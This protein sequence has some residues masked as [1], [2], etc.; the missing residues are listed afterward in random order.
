MSQVSDEQIRGQVIASLIRDGHLVF[1]EG[2]KVDVEDGRVLL[3]G[4]VRSATEKAIAGRLAAMAPGVREVVDRLTV[5]TDGTISDA[6][7]AKAA[8]E[9]LALADDPALRGLGVKVD[10]GVAFLEGEVATLAQEEAATRVVGSVK[11]ME[12]VVSNLSV[13][14]EAPAGAVLPADD[15]TLVSFASGALAEAGIDLRE[16]QIDAEKGIVYLRGRVRSEEER[17]RA[18]E[19]VKAAPGVRGVR[20]R[21]VVRLSETSQ[22]PDEALAARVIHAFRDDGRVSPTQVKVSAR[23]GVVTLTG[24]VDSIDGHNAAVEVARRVPGVRQVVNQVLITD[25][26]STRSDDKGLEM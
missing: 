18:T 12:D 21:L 9:A 15:A 22:D 23:G 20:N 5:V 2:V 8:Q 3:S 25:R 7:L 13:A 10:D 26:T 6:E 16:E 24:Q 14:A 11:G 4:I 17:R 19:V 1:A